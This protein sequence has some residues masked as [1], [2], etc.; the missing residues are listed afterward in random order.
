MSPCRQVGRLKVKLAS[1]ENRLNHAAHMT[2]A[3]EGGGFGAR[4][5]EKLKAV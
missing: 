1:L 5:Q 4:L 2:K 3:G